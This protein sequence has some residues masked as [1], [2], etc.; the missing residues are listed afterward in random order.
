MVKRL[1]KYVDEIPL[2]YTIG[3][4]EHLPRNGWV[5]NPLDYFKFALINGMYD[6]MEEYTAL[7]NAD[8][9]Y[10]E[11]IWRWLHVNNDMLFLSL[12]VNLLSCMKEVSCGSKRRIS[13][14][15]FGELSKQNIK[16]TF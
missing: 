15:S 7:F 6:F 3:N 1:S 13:P 8:N 4:N 9:K 14:L 12:C 2:Q 5:I 16:A 11:T 10:K